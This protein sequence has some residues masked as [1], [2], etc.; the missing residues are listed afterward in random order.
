MSSGEFF[1]SEN[2]MQGTMSEYYDDTAIREQLK[3]K[4]DKEEGKSLSTNDYTNEDKQKLD[5]LPLDPIETESDPTVPDWAKQPEKPIYR[6][7]ELE[8]D[9]IPYWAMTP[10]KPMYN[11]DEIEMKPDFYK[12]A[13]HTHYKEEILD[14]EVPS[15]TSELENDSDF[16]NSEFVRNEM[17]SIHVPT[18]TSELYND[19]DFVNSQYVKDI[20]NE[21]VYNI[22]GGEY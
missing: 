11:W 7:T 5:N 16:V 12:P 21:A 3:N 6:M 22:L 20:V 9:L 8:N 18:S 1:G 2:L 13:S 14:L 17:M 10:E 19:S 4:V 15:R